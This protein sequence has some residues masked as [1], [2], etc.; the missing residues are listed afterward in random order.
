MILTKALCQSVINLWLLSYKSILHCLLVILKHF[1]PVGA[2][3]NF[4][5]RGRRRDTAGGRDVST[6]F[7]GAVQHSRSCNA[8]LSCRTSSGA[9]LQ[10]VSASPLWKS[11]RWVAKMLNRLSGNQCPGPLRLFAGESCSTV[12]HLPISRQELVDESC[13]HSS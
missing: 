3:L 8:W 6:W 10:W 13:S 1:L 12:W 11:L 9:H 5:S 4:V 7:P 2:M